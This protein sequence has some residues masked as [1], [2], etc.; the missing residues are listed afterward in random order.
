METDVNPLGI[1]FISVFGLPPVDYVRLAAE[2]GCSH[3]S[4]ALEPIDYNPQGYPA[5][6]LK[7]DK[8]LRRDM[9]TAAADHGVS[10]TV[11]EGLCVFPGADV[12]AYEADLDAM[13]ELGVSLINTVSFDPDLDRTFEQL[14]R[15]TELARTRGIRALLEFVPIFTV[16]DLPTAVRAAQAIPGLGLMIDTMH[17]MRSGAEPQALAELDP[18]WIGHC[19][20]CDAPRVPVIADYMEEAMYERLPPGAGDARIGEVLRLIPRDVV[21]SLEIPQRSLA[22]KGVGPRER[23]APCVEAL[24]KLLAME[25]A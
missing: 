7:T 11:G 20:V 19:Q 4:T 13:A 10:V 3:L 17:L 2:L 9:A 14:S 6:S 22:E 24:R 23:L 21:V 5:W 25:T 12:A 18:A 1:D 8:A 15:L 16:K